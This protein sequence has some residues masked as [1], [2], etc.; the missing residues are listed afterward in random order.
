MPQTPYSDHQHLSQIVQTI[1]GTKLPAYFDCSTA[2][3]TSALVEMTDT[4][5]QAVPAIWQIILYTVLQYTDFLKVI[6]YM[7]TEVLRELCFYLKQ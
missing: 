2:S 1:L 6:H 7:P 3:P 5:P 4:L